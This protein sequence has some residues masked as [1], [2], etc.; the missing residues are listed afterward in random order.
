MVRTTLPATS[1]IHHH[2]RRPIRTMHLFLLTGTLPSTGHPPSHILPRS[3]PVP[4]I[5]H[6]MMRLLRVPVGVTLRATTRL[7]T[8]TTTTTARLRA[9]LACALKVQSL[10]LQGVTR[11]RRG[12]VPVL[13]LVSVPARVA[14]VA[15]VV[16][17]VVL[18][19]IFVR[20]A[21]T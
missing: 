1:N 21:G 19:D 15:M 7:P 18:F 12:R 20:G 6:I 5:P 16:V 8:A 4:H 2:Q 11:A 17:L 10:T 14:A 13:M 3:R 9:R